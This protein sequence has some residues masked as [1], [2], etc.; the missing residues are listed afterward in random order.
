MVGL[1][2]VIHKSHQVSDKL[3]KMADHKAKSLAEVQ[4]IKNK[5]WVLKVD[6][7]LPSLHLES[8][9]LFSLPHQ[10]ANCQVSGTLDAEPPQ[11][12]V[13]YDHWNNIFNCSCTF[14]RTV[15]NTY[16]PEDE[17]SIHP[18]YD[19]LLNIVNAPP[20]SPLPQK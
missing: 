3:K 8:C 19:N 15:I 11:N 17:E 18:V 14:D 5:H 10:M 7:G 12:Q 6:K 4:H 9:P 13:H 20:L 16:A 2:Y 1:H